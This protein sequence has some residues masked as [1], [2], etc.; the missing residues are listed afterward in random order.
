MGGRRRL[1]GGFKAWLP[2]H[3]STEGGLYRRFLKAAI[4]LLGHEPGG[5]ESE[6]LAVEAF[7]RAALLH[8]LATQHWAQLLH[9]RQIGKGR[10]PSER[11]IERAARRVGL[12]ATTL[13]EAT[14][15]LEELAGQ[16]R[17]RT[18]SLTDYLAR[19]RSPAESVT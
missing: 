10:R 1:R 2:D 4:E 15:R 8:D 9:R 3:R 16:H 6:R 14:A 7:A 13:K 19:R 11:R 5:S 12:Q 17:Q 18:T